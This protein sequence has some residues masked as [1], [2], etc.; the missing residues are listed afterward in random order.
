MLGRLRGLVPEKYKANALAVL[1][2]FLGVALS[3]LLRIL[4]AQAGG[5]LSPPDSGPTPNYADFLFYEFSAVGSDLLVV[6]FSLLIGAWLSASGD[7]AKVSKAFG[8]LAALMLFALAILLV[9]GLADG[10]VAKQEKVLVPAAVSPVEKY[11]AIESV[12]SKATETPRE[13]ASA[14]EP[15]KNTAK[16]CEELRAAKRYQIYPPVILGALAIFFAA[17]RLGN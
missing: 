5:K 16:A 8:P 9:K 14:P 3:L 4:E 13:N 10:A 15:T 7:H 1:I 12:C 6:A 11:N 2:G 17:I